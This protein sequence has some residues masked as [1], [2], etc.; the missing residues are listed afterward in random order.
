M[1]KHKIMWLCITVIFSPAN[2]RVW[3]IYRHYNNVEEMFSDL[4]NKSCPY[5][6]EQERILLNSPYIRQS[7]SIAEYCINHDISILSPDDELYPEKFRNI[8]CPPSVLFCMGDISVLSNSS[9]ISIIG[10][11]D[12]SDYSIKVT[13]IFSS[14][15]SQKDIT[16]VSGFAVGVDRSAHL[17]A[18]KSGGKTIA[19]LG[20]GIMYD[21]PK[22]TMELKKLISQNGAVISEYYPTAQCVPN[23]FK[24]RN[25]LISAISDGVLVVQAGEK[26]GAINTVSH[27]L[28]QG[29]DIFVIPPGNIFDNK[30]KGQSSLIHDGAIPVF[31]VENILE[32]LE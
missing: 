30:Y 18:I 29:K 2:R 23:N 32:F 12:A 16:V 13:D 14:E 27:A 4:K 9:C 7:Q 15:L 26:S 10:S 25:R 24:V 11:R 8:D 3:E 22:G 20:S 17:S 31:S 28:E 5:I 21:Y 1:D 6:T 19:I